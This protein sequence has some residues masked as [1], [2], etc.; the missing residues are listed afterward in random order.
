MEKVLVTGASG[1]LGACIYKDLSKT[2][3]VDKL[4]IRLEK[5]KPASLDYDLVVHC[6]GALRYRKGQHQSANAEGTRKLIRGLKKKTKFVY[7]SSKSIYGLGYEGTFNE[8]VTPEPNDDYGITKYEGELAVIESGFPYIII[9]PSTLIGL[10]VNN[11]GPAFP[12]VIIQTLYSGNDINLFDPD[13]M[14]EYLDVMDLARIVSRL[15]E[16][17]NS[18][19]EIY[20]SAGP[21]RSLHNLVCLIEKQI[22]LISDNPGKVNKINKEPSGSLFLDSSK[23]ENILGKDIYTP[24]EKIVELIGEFISQ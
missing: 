24:D 13:V 7:I 1:Y 10:G 19:N 20:N 22:A 21:K 2:W 5:I 16:T 8:E 12:S 4:Q 3:S 6:A 14:H 9:R 23:L 17:K 11:L 18:W 15:I